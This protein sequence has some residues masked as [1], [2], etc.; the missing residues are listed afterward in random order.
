MDLEG[1]N[2]EENISLPYDFARVH[3]VLAYLKE[4][5]LHVIAEKKL[6]LEMYQELSRVLRSDFLSEVC[7][8]KDFD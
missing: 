5:K 6:S 1:Q 4:S 3:R 2:S 7:S 8:P